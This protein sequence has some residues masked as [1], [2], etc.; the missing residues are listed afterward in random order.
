MVDRDEHH[1]KI[2]WSQLRAHSECK[3][4]AFLYRE[5]HRGPAQDLRGYYHGMVVDSAMRGWLADPDRRPGQMAGRIDELIDRGIADAKE[6]GDGVVRWKSSTDRADLR[7]FC[8]ELVNRLEPLLEQHVIPY[9]HEVAYRFSVDATVPYL[10]GT[11]TRISLVGE[12][13]LYVHP[14]DSHAVWDLKGTR[15]NAYW[16]KVI[17]QLIF[18]DIATL[19]ITGT[20]PAYVGLLQPMCD[21][22]VLA[23][24][25][26]D[27]D[28]RVM[29]ARVIALANDRW[30][31]DV[32]CKADTS[33][34][35]WCDVKH[36]C[37]RYKPTG[38]T[39][40]LL[41]AGLRATLGE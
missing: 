11:P 2:S 5:G 12:M 3:Q 24:T 13:D 36:A 30:S 7:E 29:W 33:G 6:S 38:N 25:V 10:D 35:N 28:R 8:V 1:L 41:G 4:K 37:A 26:S 32:A 22:Q 19:S 21:Q 14:Q 20:P 23:F 34:C 18:Y 27:D 31:Q 40:S 39:I 15:D 16:R 9:P 17:G